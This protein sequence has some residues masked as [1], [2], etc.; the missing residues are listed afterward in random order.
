M[1]AKSWT[2]WIFMMKNKVISSALL[3]LCI[4]DCLKMEDFPGGWDSLHYLREDIFNHSEQPVLV[5][6]FKQKTLTHHQGFL[7]SIFIF[8][9]HS[10][11][12]LYCRIRIYK[13]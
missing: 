11:S 1:S 8:L 4:A 10:A 9:T 12:I 13:L 6:T 3:L 2:S 5:T 7:F